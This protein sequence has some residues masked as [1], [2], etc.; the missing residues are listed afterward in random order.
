MSQA[1]ELEKLPHHIIEE[2][3][4]RERK[5]SFVKAVLLDIFFVFYSI[6]VLQRAVYYKFVLDMRDLP[7]SWFEVLNI[8]AISAGVGFL[9][10]YS[11]TSLSCK[12]FGIAKDNKVTKWTTEIF[13]WFLFD[14]TFIAGWIVT[15]DIDRGPLQRGRNPGS[16]ENLQ[17]AVPPGARHLR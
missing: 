4:Q 13:A 9:W 12:L 2:T 5:L 11:G 6:L 14:I 8:L 1:S 17:R 16:R 15:R 7:F 10:T 3:K